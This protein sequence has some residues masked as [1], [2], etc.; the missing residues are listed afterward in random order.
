[1]SISNIIEIGRRSLFAQQSAIN[2]TGRNIANVNTI[3]YSRQRLNLRQDL[4]G[5]SYLGSFGQE[6]TSQIRQSFT[7]IQIWREN[8][9]LGQYNTDANALA[10]V[11]DIFAEP[12]DAGIANLMTEFWN[13]WNDLSNDPDSDTAKIVVRDKA[14]QLSNG[15]NRVHNELSNHHNQIHF[16]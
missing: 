9:L 12:T 14:I 15:F 7:D 2:T 3:G 16:S 1:M 10:Q 5:V 11:Q 8:S 13:S 6:A 4:T